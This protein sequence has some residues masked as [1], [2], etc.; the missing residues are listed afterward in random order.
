[1]AREDGLFKDLFFAIGV[2]TVALGATY[3]ITK[4]VKK[5]LNDENESIF[6]EGC[7]CTESKDD[8]CFD[9]VCDQCDE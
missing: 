7:I 3:L 8:N 5:R 4:A 6:G 2:A 9:E 1:M